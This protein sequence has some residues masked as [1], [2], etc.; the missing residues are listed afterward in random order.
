MP[1]YLFTV[2]L[3]NPTFVISDLLSSAR[4]HNFTIDFSDHSF[5]IGESPNCA[6]LPIV[7]SSD[8][9]AI[10]LAKRSISVKSV[11][12][13]LA[14]ASSLPVLFQNC[15]EIP[16]SFTNGSFSIEVQTHN[17]KLSNE[18]RR[19]YIAD[20]VVA[21]SLRG[22][23]DLAHPEIRVL[24]SLQYVDQGP[25]DPISVYAS[26]FL[27]EGNSHFPDLF[28]LPGRCFINK[29]SM[30]S[31]LAL[32]TAGQAL[33]GPGMIA[34]DP[35]CGSGSIL[36]AAASIG[37]WVIGGDFDR[38]SMYQTEERSIFA[39]FRQYGLTGRLLGLL[40][41]DFLRDSIRAEPFLDA[42]I[43]DPPY[44]IREKCVAED[45]SPLLPLLLKLYA[46]A[47]VLLRAGGRLV[48]W[49]PAGYAIDVSKELPTHPALRLISHCRQGLGTR[50]CRELITLEKVAEIKAE[51]EFNAPDASWLKVRYLVFSKAEGYRGKNRKEKKKFAKELKA[52]LHGLPRPGT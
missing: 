34:L 47:A 25:P 35:F 14:E 12:I 22:R 39:N 45:V 36:V 11:S 24:L 41:A 3:R 21:L 48:Y 13:L 38:P 6:F 37:A 16:H 20:F 4:Y 9:D 23:V 43:T 15:S 31:A 44:G 46:T 52:K 33:L 40:R 49:L 50:Y 51:V 32:Y 27:A 42:I 26:V 30:E 19:Q 5:Q 7:L 8:E 28:A 17:H 10:S 18:V 1:R 29:T 2:A